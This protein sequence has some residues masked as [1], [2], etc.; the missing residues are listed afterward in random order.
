V[1]RVATSA[2]SCAG[3][4]PCTSG[5]TKLALIAV[6]L[7]PLLLGRPVPFT[8]AA[9]VLLELFMDLCASVAFVA[10]PAAAGA[11]RRPP[12]APGARFLGAAELA[13]ARRLLSFGSRL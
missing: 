10:E 9:I 7:T 11:M 8:P 3:R 12:R 6:T 4:S 13:A 5:L 1:A 2:L